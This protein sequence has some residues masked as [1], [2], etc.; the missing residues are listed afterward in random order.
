MKQNKGA[1]SL[2]DPKTFAERCKVAEQCMADLKLGIPALVDGMDDAANIAYAG[3]PERLF[4]IGK[5]GNVAY[6][7][8][9]GPFHF[10]PDE[11]AKFLKEHLS[12][13]ARC[14]E[15]Y[16]SPRGVGVPAEGK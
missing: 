15:G 3:W 7:G 9:M 10:N 16:V 1:C 2:E 6:A 13:P 5:D 14:R 12:D 4:V 8:G 11:M